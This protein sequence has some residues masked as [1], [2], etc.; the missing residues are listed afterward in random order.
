[1]WA[2]GLGEGI[3]MAAAAGTAGV[4]AATVGEPDGWA[5]ALLVWAGS[6]AGGVVEGFAVAL[7]Q[8]AVLK[9]WLPWLSKAHWT[10]ATVAVAAGG[11]ALGMAPSALVL[12]QLD[13]GQ[14]AGRQLDGAGEAAVQ[15]SGP[16]LW[17]MP[18]AGAVLG[19]ALGAVFG[20]AQGAVLRGH[21]ANP[22]SWI[23]ANAA[24]WAVAMAVIMTGA[25]IP[26][27]PWPWPQLLALGIATGVLAGLAIGAVT[28]MFLPSLND[29]A[30]APKGVANRVV[31]WLLRGPA[32]TV[33]S[34]SLLELR[35]IGR[36]SGREIALAAQYA[37]C[38]GT[39]VVLPGKPAR[40][41]WWRNFER[42]RL[43]AVNLRGKILA[44]RAEVLRP[45]DARYDQAA[46]AYRAR[47]PKTSIGAADPLV[48]LTVTIAAPH[49]GGQQPSTSRGASRPP[50]GH[51]ATM[52][53]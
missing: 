32:H 52:G 11:W 39:L 13:R 5:V 37:D 25:S 42:P 44:A 14:F 24:G 15:A 7:L 18:A 9:P 40:K 38:D 30:P 31:I 36:R 46:R 33:L 21:V 34:D 43:A 10:G 16:P 41:K 45:Q 17:A 6:I 49:P 53:W 35:F 50:S 51:D 23:T 3:G 4:L 47:W 27:G 12:W 2:C 19:L 22:R 48:L 8:F 29:P 28:G 20:A 26:S 1:M